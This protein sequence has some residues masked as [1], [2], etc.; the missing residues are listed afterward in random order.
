[1]AA[2]NR[3]SGAS[4][5]PGCDEIARLFGLEIA[6]GDLEADRVDVVAGAGP[7][8]GLQCAAALVGGQ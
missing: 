6:V 4:N 5:S 8:A 3:R 1:L 2:T 7:G